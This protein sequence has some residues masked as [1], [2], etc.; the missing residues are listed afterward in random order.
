MR[1]DE[2]QE[3]FV[4]L[5]YDEPGTPRAGS[6]LRA[7]LLSCPACRKE[8]DDLKALQSLLK[9]WEDAPPLRPVTIPRLPETTRRKWFPAQWLS[10]AYAAAAILVVLVLLFSLNAEVTWNQQ[11]FHYNSHVFGRSGD[12]YTKAQVRDILK[13]VLDDS[14]ARMT[15]TNYLMMQRLMD[16]VE[17]DRQMDLRFVRDSL[18]D[19]TRGASRPQ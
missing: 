2:I 5:L 18:R 6:E 14:E 13:R 19:N 15:E 4:D 17:Q 8:L 11:G 12:Y 1:C 16:T 10:P 3:R 9:N 7:H